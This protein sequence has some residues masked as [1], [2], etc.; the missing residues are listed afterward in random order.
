MRD[1]VLKVRKQ[2]FDHDNGLLSVSINDGD[3]GLYLRF[4]FASGEPESAE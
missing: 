1:D 4:L 2:R 3:D